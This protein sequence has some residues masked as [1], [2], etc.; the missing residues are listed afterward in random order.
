MINIGKIID[1]KFVLPEKPLDSYIYVLENVRGIHGFKS[2][3]DLKIATLNLENELGKHQYKIG[4][5]N[6]CFLENN[7]K[8]DIVWLFEFKTDKEKKVIENDNWRMSNGHKY[9][10][11]MYAYKGVKIPAPTKCSLPPPKPKRKTIVGAPL[12]VEDPL[13]PPVS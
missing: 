9:S 4:L 12:S 8:T 2:L 13:L 1:N 11:Y 10:E 6:V 7:N 5:L 3:V